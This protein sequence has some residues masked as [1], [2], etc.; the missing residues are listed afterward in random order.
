MVLGISRTCQKIQDNSEKKTAAAEAR[1]KILDEALMKEW[2]LPKEG[3]IWW[4]WEYPKHARIF[5]FDYHKRARIFTNIE[6]I[7]IRMAE[8]I[9]KWL[10]NVENWCV[11]FVIVNITVYI[12]EKETPRVLELA[13]QAKVSAKK[14]LELINIDYKD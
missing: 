1:N 7:W 14:K 13:F 9:T 4:C 11:M 3:H 12:L 6:K 5:I 8:H 10:G 2:V